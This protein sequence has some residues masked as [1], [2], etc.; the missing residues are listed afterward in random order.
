M[1]GQLINEKLVAPWLTAPIFNGYQLHVVETGSQYQVVSLQPDGTLVLDVPLTSIPPGATVELFTGEEAPV[2]ATRLLTQTPLNRPFPPLEMRLGTT[3]GT[4]AL[5][6][7]K[8]GRVALLVT[9][10]FKD[11]LQIGTQQRPDLFQLAIPP[12]EVLY[13]SVLEVTERMTADGQVLLPL[14]DKQLTALID[15]LKEAQPDAIAISLL[16]AYKNPTHEYQLRDA[17]LKAGFTNIT[18]SNTVSVTPQ[19]VARTQTT[20]VDAYL[21]PVMQSYLTNVQQQ[22]GGGPSTGHTHPVRV[23]SSSGGLVRADLF[24][25]KDSLLSGPAG[26]VIGAAAMAANQPVLTLDMGGTSTDVARIQQ[27]LDYRFTTKIGAF[28]LQLPSLAIETVAAGGGSICWFEEHGSASGQLRVGPQS[29]GANP[30]PACYGATK[31]G[32][33][34]LL[35]ITDVNLLLGKLHPHQFGIPVFPEKAE[36]AL[37]AILRQIALKTGNQPDALTVLRGFEQIANELMAGAIR[38]ISIARGFDPTA[39]QLLVFGGAGGL[40]G[41]AIARLLGMEQLIL[42]FDGGL[43]SAYGIGQAQIERMA[44]LSI[45]KPLPAVEQD[46]ATL[47]DNLTLTATQALRQD[48]G[49]DVPVETR[50]VS[51][52]LRLSGQEAT[53]DVPFSYTLEA[54]FREK[55][56]H[57]YGHYPGNASGQSPAIEVESIRVIVSTV[58]QEQPEPGVPVTHRHAV[59]A[60]QAGAYSAL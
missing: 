57:L 18:L 24:Q 5:L 14:A 22:L 27:T 48:V 43:L 44:S 54:D 39:Y 2:L 34:P 59:P 56:Q 47:V 26:G 20:V 55:Y 6:E 52:F 46:L 30:G 37:Q 50:A 12:A 8:G 31:P 58:R 1:R 51:I 13:D 35:T 53:I 33:P 40:H 36:A 23:M 9:K 7:R 10:G 16:N 17:L 38:R 28:D 3:K 29:A 32:Q 60:F 11:L 19:Y 49:L 45:L 25:P 15:Q 42:P 4:N 21:T 41:C